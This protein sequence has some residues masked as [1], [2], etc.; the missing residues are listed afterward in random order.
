MEDLFTKYKQ[1]E[2]EE[3][4]GKEIHGF[5][6]SLAAQKNNYRKILSLKRRFMIKGQYHHVLSAWAKDLD[7]IFE[8]AEK[9]LR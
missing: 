1:R 2:Q 5:M 9:E 8:L 4:D 3:R 6:D 7:A